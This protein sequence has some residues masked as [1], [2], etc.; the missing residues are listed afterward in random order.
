[1]GIGVP[2][3]SGVKCEVND[4]SQENINQMNLD[5]IPVCRSHDKRKIGEILT[6][7]VTKNGARFVLGYI[8]TETD[9]G[10]FVEQEMKEGY[11]SELSLTHVLL[12]FFH[13]NKSMPHKVPV[14]ISLVNQ[15][16]RNGCRVL[17]HCSE[18]DIKTLSDRYIFQGNNKEVLL[19]QFQQVPTVKTIM[20]SQAAA[21]PAQ[22][23][24]PVAPQIPAEK[25]SIG[26]VEL[27]SQQ[28]AQLDQQTLIALAMN[29][30][31]KTQEF[32][33]RIQEEE[34]RREETAKGEA[35]KVRQ[36]AYQL[37]ADSGKEQQAKEFQ[38]SYQKLF[39]GKTM[40]QLIDANRALSLVVEN[41]RQHYE[42]YRNI[43]Q[44][45]E[46]LKQQVMSGQ[47]QQPAQE[48]ETYAQR[49]LKGISSY[50][51]TKSTLPY[52]GTGARFNP[53]SA[54]SAEKQQQKQEVA[55]STP[56]P[57]NAASD[58]LKELLGTAP[59]KPI[60]QLVAPG[61][62]VGPPPVHTRY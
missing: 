41:G 49:L 2:P 25:I 58:R 29:L 46:Q 59:S 4:Y 18:A 20:E 33:S 23:T 45:Y 28:L 37:L 1:M 43:A 14:E 27:D 8:N 11:L 31:K 22:P 9:A 24:E 15:G 53:M 10:K 32:S 48:Q 62:P 19:Q 50:G 61:P 60:S 52:T 6:S 16:L 47:A 55:V 36:M 56:P 34:Q 57:A 42:N 12:P 7:G 5:S 40:D 44:Q 21:T 38:E 3:S 35:E 51:P 39:A 30:G 17:F 54:L 13:K 26:D